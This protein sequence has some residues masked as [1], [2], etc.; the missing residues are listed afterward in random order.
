M[1]L[2]LGDC[3]PR[4]LQPFQPLPVWASSGPGHR[5]HPCPSR[6]IRFRLGSES[7]W[8]YK[9]VCGHLLEKLQSPHP[10]GTI[11]PGPRDRG[12]GRGLLEM[13]P[14][15]EE[16]RGDPGLQ[17]P[18]PPS[19]L[20]TPPPTPHL[21]PPQGCPVRS[22]EQGGSEHGGGGVLGAKGQVG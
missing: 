12:R 20:G 11:W 5:P 22:T 19:V 1:W 18:P 7:S 4:R 10:A 15:K 13:G 21:F 17:V 8:P 2:P 9:A 6:G 16:G 14:V 3:G